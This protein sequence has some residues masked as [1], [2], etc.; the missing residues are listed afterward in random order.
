MRIIE[1][2]EKKREKMSRLA[3]EMLRAGGKLMQCIDDLEDGVDHRDEDDE[4]DYGDRMYDDI[5]D[6]MDRR[7]GYGGRYGDG[8]NQ[9]RG[10]PM[11]GISGRYR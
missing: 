4:E 3:E 2:T 6:R 10:F 5:P 1:I 11:Y 9:R 8:M 7:G